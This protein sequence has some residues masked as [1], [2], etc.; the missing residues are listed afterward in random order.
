MK[1]ITEMFSTAHRSFLILTIIVGKSQSSKITGSGIPEL[2][3]RVKKTELRIMT[4]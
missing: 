3:N 4:L 2:E 1:L